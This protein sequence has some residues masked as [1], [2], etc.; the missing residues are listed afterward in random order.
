[1]DA[2]KETLKIARKS[3]DVAEDGIATVK[4]SAGY[5][6]LKAARATLDTL[7]AG[8]AVADAGLGG[9]NAVDKIGQLVVDSGSNGLVTVEDIEL[10][11]S[12]RQARGTLEITVDIE[13]T[14]VGESFEVQF[15]SGMLDLAPL[16]EQVADEITRL[17]S[18]QDSGVW[19]A[20]RAKR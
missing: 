14:E 16:A 7:R 15:G 3:R 13:G 4:K 6:R 19:K 11:A 18:K 8:K 17:A 9:W 1:M 10:S 12:L 20:M 2:A 5:V